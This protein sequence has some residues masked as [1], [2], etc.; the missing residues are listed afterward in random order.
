V[1]YVILALLL[2]M[3]DEAEEQS[4]R[5]DLQPDRPDLDLEPTR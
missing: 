1:N 3:S 4:E 5:A 2:R